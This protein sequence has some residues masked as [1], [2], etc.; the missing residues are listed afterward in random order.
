MVD[1]YY[2]TD[3]VY[4]TFTWLTVRTPPY[5]PNNHKQY[6]KYL[7][8]YILIHIHTYTHTYIHTYVRTYIHTYIYTCTHTYIHTYT[9]TY[10]H[11]FLYTY[12]YVHTLSCVH[13][14]TYRIISPKCSD[15]AQTQAS[16]MQL[17]WQFLRV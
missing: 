11:T 9:H 6:H 4:Y 8:T 1:R 16:P 12:T 7:Y 13:S 17:T 3:D 2:P 5:V 10:M 14:R 15:T